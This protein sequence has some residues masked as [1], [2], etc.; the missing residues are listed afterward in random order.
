MVNKHD[1]VGLT[2]TKTDDTDKKQIPG[3]VTFRKTGRNFRKPASLV[4][5]DDIVKC[6]KIIN[7]YCEYVLLF[8]LSKVLN[9]KDELLCSIIYIP[10]EGRNC[11]S[12]DCFS[13][14]DKSCVCY[15]G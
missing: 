13:D 15:K 5:K 2:K 11:S 6:V 3:F 10:L 12:L 7:T 14:I 8:M 1:I 4:V 9:T